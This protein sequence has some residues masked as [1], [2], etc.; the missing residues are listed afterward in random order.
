VDRC[1]GDDL[2]HS[3]GSDDKVSIFDATKSLSKKR[4][5]KNDPA[6]LT[7]DGK[8]TTRDEGDNFHVKDLF[9][10]ALERREAGRFFLEEGNNVSPTAK[11]EAIFSGTACL[12]GTSW[13]L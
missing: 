3:L 12:F 9:K 2:S 13:Y 11:S 1:E 4:D 7:K 6:D 8:A 10:R 5:R